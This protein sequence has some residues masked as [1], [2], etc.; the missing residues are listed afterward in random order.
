MRPIFRSFTDTRTIQPTATKQFDVDPRDS[1]FRIQHSAFRIQHSKL[2]PAPH[3]DDEPDRD[4]RDASGERTPA[5]D[6][7][8]AKGSSE[9]DLIARARRDA[10]SGSKAKGSTEE[11]RNG[12]GSHGHDPNGGDRPLPPADSFPGYEIVREIHRGAQGVVYQAIQ[13]ATRRK[14]ALKVLLDGAFAS[15]AD[16]NR[17]EREIAILSQLDH[18][19]IVAIHDSGVT[20]GRHWFV[21]DYVSGPP[22]D[23]WLAQSRRSTTEILRMMIRICDAV[24]AAHLRGIIHRDLKPGNIRIDAGGEP[25]ILDFGL[26]KSVNGFIGQF[27]GEE[28]RMVTVT[29]QF[30][31]SLPWASPEQAE[32]NPARIDMRSDVYSLGVILYQLLTGGFPYEVVGHLRDVLD[33]IMRAEPTRPS[34]VGRGINDEVETIVLKS[35]SKEPQRRYQSAHELARDIERYLSGAPIEAKR[36]SGLYVLRKTLRRF[37]VPVAVIVAFVVLLAVGSTLL[38]RAERRSAERAEAAVAARTAADRALAARDAATG[39]LLTDMLG[40][41]DPRDG[42]GRSVRVVE[43]LDAGVGSVAERFGNDPPTDA[44]VRSLIGSAYHA[45]GLYAAAEEQ[46]NAALAL[47]RRHGDP[48]ALAEALLDLGQT[49]IRMGRHDEA[50]ALATEAVGIR[51]RIDG[52]AAVSTAL[53]RGVL[54]SALAGTGRYEDAAQLERES[55]DALRA[56]LANDDI[57][58][59]RAV[60]QLGVRLRTLRRADD[61]EPLL[62]E[63]HETLVRLRGPNALETMVAAGNLANCL[64]HLGRA[65]EALPLLEA[66][67]DARRT[68]VGADDPRLA[69]ALQRLAEARFYVLGDAARAEPAVAEAASIRT[70][71]LGA[72]H[73]HTANSLHLHGLALVDLDRAD[74]AEPLLIEALRIRLGRLPSDHRQIAEARSAL[75]HAIATQGRLD[76]ALPLLRRGAESLRD[77]L[78]AADPA[79]KRAARN[80][81][82]ALTAAGHHAE[83]LVWREIADR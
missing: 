36:D 1:A 3:P 81:A 13:K 25:R 10:G 59:A 77:A 70:R 6:S 57:R 2:M 67:V 24:H 26:A 31:G 33:N 61:A 72:D 68:V 48:P 69:A 18:P 54:A 66:S 76:E 56:A 34:T 80:L 5:P 17:F 39:F 30:I 40:A 64:L 29:G 32:G 78:G 45:L 4:D 49:L 65:D 38:W 44:H 55:L 7:P 60:H 23:A 63:A 43:A 37:R 35:L 16:R 14:V 74:E 62:R 20:E 83:A 53:A 21:M 15:P 42:D 82:D 58:V 27:D 73:L 19:H 47:Q 12:S 22:L 71:R 52:T 28:G 50:I 46:R 8:V 51:A 11:K 75:G 41:V 9:R 79:T